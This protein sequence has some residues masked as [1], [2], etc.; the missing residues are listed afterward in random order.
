MNSPKTVSKMTLR[1][2][3]LFLSCIIFYSSSSFAEEPIIT[4]QD[5]QNLILDPVHYDTNGKI[6]TASEQSIKNAFAALE[7]V[8]AEQ[9]VLADKYKTVI[10]QADEFNSLHK[11]READFSVYRTTENRE[12]VFAREYTQNYGVSRLL[13]ET[14][15][16]R[17]SEYTGKGGA[18]YTNVGI[19][20]ADLGRLFA[21]SLSELP[22]VATIAQNELVKLIEKYEGPLSVRIESLKATSKA[23]ILTHKDYVS[24]SVLTEFI[25]EVAVSK[26]LSSDENTSRAALEFLVKIKAVNLSLST[27]DLIE[28]GLLKAINYNGK[29]LAV[30]NGQT[31]NKDVKEEISRRNLDPMYKKIFDK[32]F[33]SAL[34]GRVRCSSIFNF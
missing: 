23:G 22:Q 7:K 32:V 9:I 17:N 12:G 18:L 28:I 24:V 26:S 6:D 21:L 27:K 1:S 13:F 16:M 25:Y 10:K 30:E 34:K 5:F 31:R 19:L 15:E 33:S 20:Q 8:L 4:N 11:N 2:L 3:M 14:Y 29:F